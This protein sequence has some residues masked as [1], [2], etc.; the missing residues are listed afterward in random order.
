MKW[1]F[2]AFSYFRSESE[3][4][5][6]SREQLFSGFQVA[7][8]PPGAGQPGPGVHI[9]CH[10]RIFL[11]LL[12]EHQ[13][14]KQGSPSNWEEVK[15]LNVKKERKAQPPATSSMP[16]DSSNS[17]TICFPQAESNC[18]TC[19]R[20]Y[21]ADYGDPPPSD[22]PPPP[23]CDSC[24][25]PTEWGFTRRLENETMHVYHCSEFCM[26]GGSRLTTTVYTWTL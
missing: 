23:A 22:A 6:S 15:P 21:H 9:L 7:A 4:G 24:K 10:H 5:C 13:E 16:N 17:S 2:S 8:P 18:Q 12:L 20:E 14:E 26:F 1:S 19:T 25:G 11:Q 3:N